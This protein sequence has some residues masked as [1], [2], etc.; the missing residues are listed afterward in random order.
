MIM[1]RDHYYDSWSTT[2]FFSVFA[3][4]VGPHFSL[5]SV[6]SVVCSLFCCMFHHCVFSIKL[7]VFLKKKKNSTRDLRVLSDGRLGV[8]LMVY[9][10][11]C[12]TVRSWTKTN[13]P[14]AF[15]IICT[16]WCQDIKGKGNFLTS[17]L[18]CKAKSQAY[19]T[20]HCHQASHIAAKSSWTPQCHIIQ[21]F[22][23]FC[24]IQWLSFFFYAKHLNN[25]WP[26]TYGKKDT[27]KI[28]KIMGWSALLPKIIKKKGEQTFGILPK[29]PCPIFWGLPGCFDVKK[30]PVTSGQNDNCI[31]VG[32]RPH[33]CVAIYGNGV[34]VWPMRAT[35]VD[36]TSFSQDE[37][38]IIR[39]F[40]ATFFWFY[41]E[42]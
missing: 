41:L 38:G 33:G 12:A 27:K 8:W 42:K 40:S 16:M 7:F 4:V 23:W 15:E 37:K 5:V 19:A 14:L 9:T 28:W 25:C 18:D 6:H 34:R 1:T 29:S 3:F 22:L 13:R 31:C 26:K 21:I 2:I 11:H 20:H 35:T 39:L 17:V 10:S 24:M 32:Q 36:I 30:C